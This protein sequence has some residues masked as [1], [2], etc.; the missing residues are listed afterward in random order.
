MIWLV[1][2][3]HQRGFRSEYTECQLI[4]K[5]S[6][7][8]WLYHMTTYLT[9]KEIQSRLQIR[10]TDILNSLSIY[11]YFFFLSFTLLVQD[12]G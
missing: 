7:H 4:K 6:L 9:I 1:Q 10:T 8:H 11:I 12:F 5:L 2:D 3:T